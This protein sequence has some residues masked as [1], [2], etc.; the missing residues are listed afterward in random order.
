MLKPSMAPEPHVGIAADHTFHIVYKFASKVNFIGILRILFHQREYHFVMTA[1][2][3]MNKSKYHGAFKGD[4]IPGCASDKRSR[5]TKALEPQSAG[6][7]TRVLVSG[8]ADHILH[9]PVRH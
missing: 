3:F 8:Q 6:R 4:R 2:F 7:M 5:P 1:L 9:I